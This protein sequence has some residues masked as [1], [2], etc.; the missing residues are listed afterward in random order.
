MATER[1]GLRFHDSKIVHLLRMRIPAL[2]QPA[3]A[4]R[5]KCI[6]CGDEKELSREH[7]L[8]ECLGRFENY[9]TLDDRICTECNHKLGQLVDEQFC[10][11]GQVGYF[12]TFLGIT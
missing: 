12:R 6:Y 9:E 1:R 10:R 2:A 4:K 11:G 7:Y 5:G 8:P 3:S